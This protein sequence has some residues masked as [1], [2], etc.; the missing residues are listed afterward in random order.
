MDRDG[1]AV[2]GDHQL[3]N[4]ENNSPSQYKD[5]MMPLVLS[6]IDAVK[7]LGLPLMFISNQSGI[8][9]YT[10]LELVVQ[11]FVW[12][13]ERYEWHGIKCLGSLFCSDHGQTIYYV[14][15]EKLPSGIN[16]VK[17]IKFSDPDTN[18][19]RKP[20][21]SMGYFADDFAS[22]YGC[23]ECW[24]YVGDLSGIPGYAPSAKEP[25]SDKRFA[26]NW[27]VKYMDIQQFTKTSKEAICN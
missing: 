21:P 23:D 13:M 18:I 3:G 12:L 1:C 10:T 15:G 20:Q 14:R 17:E 24:G 8:G 19:G 7:D 26:E 11:Q 9:R 16:L 2:S 22:L 5:K 6:T 27:G 4:Y 25:D